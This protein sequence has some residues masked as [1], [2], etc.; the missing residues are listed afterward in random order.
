MAKTVQKGRLI[1]KINFNTVIPDVDPV[2]PAFLET[3]DF[4]PLALRVQ[5]MSA[6]GTG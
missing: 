1:S 4:T 6:S 2:S 3:G 5:K